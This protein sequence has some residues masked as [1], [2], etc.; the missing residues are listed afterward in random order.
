MLR[1]NEIQDMLK[2]MPTNILGYASHWKVN[3]LAVSCDYEIRLITEYRERAV[4]RS[5][6]SPFHNDL[7]VAAHLCGT[8][9]ENMEHFILE[10]EAFFTTRLGK[11]YAGL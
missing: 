4:I 5:I 1:I 6:L 3:C 11:I 2:H 9:Q 10:K 8:M 7:N